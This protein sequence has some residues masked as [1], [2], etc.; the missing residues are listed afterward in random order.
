MGADRDK[1]RF[2]AVTPPSG[3]E[4]YRAR[5]T[6]GPV[7]INRGTLSALSVGRIVPWESQRARR[8]IS[9]RRS[10]RVDPLSPSYAVA[11][12]IYRYFAGRIIAR[13]ICATGL[14]SNPRP[15]SG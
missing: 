6:L 15:C 10:I 14:L 3:T 7:F 1:S 11:G 9:A 12:W 5:W 2:E 13:H 8:L 4:N